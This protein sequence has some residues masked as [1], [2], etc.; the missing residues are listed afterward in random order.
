MINAEMNCRR[1]KG[2]DPSS[3]YSII[4][5]VNILSHLIKAMSYVY[6]NVGRLEFHLQI[7]FKS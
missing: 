5:D 2:S 4:F 1:E 3:I 7:V 6:T